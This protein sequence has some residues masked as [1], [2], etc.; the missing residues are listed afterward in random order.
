[1]NRVD[2]R[3][4]YPN[5]SL[6]PQT[7]RAPSPALLRMGMENRQKRT[8]AH[9]ISN[10]SINFGHTAKVKVALDRLRLQHLILSNAKTKGELK[11]RSQLVGLKPVSS[12]HRSSTL[13]ERNGAE[14]CLIRIKDDQP[15][16]S[17]FKKSKMTNLFFWSSLIIFFIKDDQPSHR[18]FYRV[19]L[20]Q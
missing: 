13:R 20:F 12:V 1:M 5:A 9:F 4:L 11:L 10:Q 7:A 8:R 18:I 2:Q 16:I 19:G 17:N 15:Q 14:L 3:W 6:Q